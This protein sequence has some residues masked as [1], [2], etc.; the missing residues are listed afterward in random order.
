MTVVLPRGEDSV[1]DL[2]ASLSRSSWDE[3]VGGFGEREGTVQ[4][5]RFRMEWGKLLNETLQAMG[6]VDAFLSGAA[7]FSGLS[8][9][10]LGMGLYVSK[11]KQKS[12]VDV[13]E[14]GTEAAGVTMVQIDKSASGRFT[15]RADRP[16]LFFIRERFSGTILFAGVFMSP[17]EA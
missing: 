3:L 8:Q 9:D 16:F 14:E 11:V 12:Y 1:Q 15:F 7:D 5:P 10:A 4:I 17:P 6:M 2:V 13:D